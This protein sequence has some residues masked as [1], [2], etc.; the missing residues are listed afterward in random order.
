M[1]LDPVRLMWLCAVLVLLIAS[2]ASAQ[3]RRVH[4]DGNDSFTGTSWVDEG[5]GV[6]P[7]KTLRH[8]LDE[9]NT[10]GGF[11]QIWIAMGDTGHVYTPHD[12]DY[13]V[14]FMVG[15]PVAIR[16]GF[17][18]WETSAGQRTP[19]NV[20]VLSGDLPDSTDWSTRIMKIGVFTPGA[21]YLVVLDALKF[22]G[23]GWPTDPEV[24][25]AGIETLYPEFPEET[26]VYGPIFVHDCVF[27]DLVADGNGGAIL[28]THRE[29]QLRDSQFTSCTAKDLPFGVGVGG[30]VSMDHGTLRAA[31]CIFHDNFAGASGGAVSTYLSSAVFANC[32]FRGNA[33]KDYGT[34]SGGGGAIRHTADLYA[35]KDEQPLTV[36]NCVFADNLAGPL[37]GGAVFA[38]RG[39][40]IAE[41]T[42]FGNDTNGYGGGVS[43]GWWGGGWWGAEVIL[44]LSNC[45]FWANR[46]GVGSEGDLEWQYGWDSSFDVTL[47]STYNCVDASSVPTGTGNINNDPKFVDETNRNLRLRR[48]SPAINV[49]N[50]AIRPADVEDVNDNSDPEERHPLDLDQ[51]AR[52]TGPEVDMGAYEGAPCLADLTGDG[53]V[54]GADLGTLLGSWG[55]CPGCEADLDGDGVVNGADLGTLLGAWGECPGGG[56]SMMMFG[57]GS[58]FT[59][60]ELMENYGLGSIEELVEWL[61]QFDQNDMEALLQGWFGS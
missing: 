23:P 12:D 47:S 41:C 57:G 7:W 40:S 49:G 26:D 8:A 9:L 19:G 25:S 39:A 59:P 37:G 11:D 52:F 38:E 17:E 6:G 24:L 31:R 22:V 5:G 14:S 20:S 34:A 46:A 1:R 30:A 4:P 54:N 48:Y 55:A 50:E 53:I 3:V 44:S 60:A 10:N 61:L 56:E 51:A 18:G 32:D 33:V 43:V 58:E 2:S 15:E 36:N 16:G 27:D 42:F 45:I 21:Q 28:A 35:E 13:T 29:L